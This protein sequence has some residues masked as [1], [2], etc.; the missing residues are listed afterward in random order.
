MTGRNHT[1]NIKQEL[2]DRLVDLYTKLLPDGQLQGR[3]RVEYCRRCDFRGVLDFARNF[4]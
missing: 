1:A 3:L 4:L 2:K